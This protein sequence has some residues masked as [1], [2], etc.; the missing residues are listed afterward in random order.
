MDLSNFNV[1]VVDDFEMSRKV[2]SDFLNQ[3][4]IKKYTRS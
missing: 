1:L 3:L 4:G 2:L